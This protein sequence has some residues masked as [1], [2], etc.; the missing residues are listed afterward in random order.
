[1]LNTSNGRMIQC[2]LMLWIL[3]MGVC[4]AWADSR[5]IGDLPRI[6]QAP[7]ENLLGVDTEYGV[8]RSR[9]GAR[10]RT[11]LTKPHEIKG[12]LPAIQFVQW[13]SC[14][15]IELL[16]NDQSGWAKMLRR[17]VTESHAIVLRT[18][19][20]GVGD[21]QGKPCNTLDYETELEYHRQA[22]ETLAQR[23]DVDPAK[24]VIFGASIGATY[25]PLIASRLP[26]LAGVAVWGG[27]ART[28]YER[29]IAFD[30]RAIE[31]SGHDLAAIS[32]AMTRY[33]EFEWLYL[34]KR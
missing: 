17:L 22:F 14:D 12:R 3:P 20:T 6:V 2:L 19:K 25:A 26:H 15:T 16:P 21:S 29:Q 8:L 13:L 11:V 1:M 7:L 23:T 5:L 9:D 27:G 4:S 31:L 18:E 32:P 30:R 34:Q 28:W 33:V 10:L 24:I